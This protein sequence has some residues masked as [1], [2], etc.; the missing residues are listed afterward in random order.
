MGRRKRKK[1]PSSRAI[2]RRKLWLANPRCHWCGTETRL[3]EVPNQGGIVKVVATIDH[4]YSRYHPLP[5]ADREMHTVLACVPCNA[6]RARRENLVFRDFVRTL[7]ALGRLSMTN[8]QKVQAFRDAISM[9]NGHD[10]SVLGE[11]ADGQAIA[12][13]Y[14]GTPGLKVARYSDA[15]IEI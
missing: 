3:P 4:L 10:H 5:A 1:K 2:R 11:D 8:R 12:L 7:E 6:M 15:I 9:I 14:I 13:T